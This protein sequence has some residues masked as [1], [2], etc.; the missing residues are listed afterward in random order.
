MSDADDIA[1][2]G[3]LLDLIRK[4][5]SLTA[6]ACA[7][8][9]H[10][11]HETAKRALTKMVDDGQLYTKMWGKTCYYVLLPNARTMP[12]PQK[13]E[14]Q[15]KTFNDGYTRASSI[16]H[17]QRADHRLEV[18]PQPGFVCHPSTKGVNLD[19]EWI[20]AHHNGEYQVKIVK[21]GTMKTTDYFADT[22]IRV[23]W[24][25]KGLNTNVACNG[26]VFLHDDTRPWTM[27]TVST[28]DGSFGL[29]SIRIHPRY[30]YYKDSKR[31][32][33]AEFRQQVFDILDVLERGGWVFDKTS[34]ERK[35]DVHE[36]INDRNLGERV[37]DYN[38]QDG[39]E[40]HFDRSHGT[41]EAELYEAN[42]AD[43]EIMVKLP[44]IIRSFG[45][46]L[47]EIQRNMT[48]MLDIQSKTVQ[49]MSPPISND[50]RATATVFQGGNMYGRL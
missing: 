25:S 10:R 40:V 37:G 4:Y 24:Q 16:P 47:V 29:L 6:N 26:K 12:D 8:Y 20:R 42:P 23:Q 9:T 49:M 31:T 36:A 11:K 15:G 7:R 30:V 38:Q 41:P 33:E 5:G 44:S 46:S 1:Y 35:G 22:D 17:F 48:L 39:D 45:E 3:T 2:M 14:A 18:I 19:R 13:W 27:R 32:A 28:K 34:I 50:P 21:V 43:V